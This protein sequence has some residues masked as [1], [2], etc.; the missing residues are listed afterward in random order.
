MSWNA[1]AKHNCRMLAALNLDG[2]TAKRAMM[3]PSSQALCVQE[4]IKSGLFGQQTE[5]ICVEKYHTKHIQQQVVLKNSIGNYKFVNA[6]FDKYSI[7]ATEDKSIDYAF[8]D[9]CGL[10]TKQRQKRIRQMWIDTEATICFTLNIHNRFLNILSSYP[11][12]D[13]DDNVWDNIK[14]E[15][16]LGGFDDEP[17]LASVYQICMAVNLF[18]EWDNVKIDSAIE[19]RNKGMK[20]PMLFL[21]LK[22]S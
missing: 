2:K 6:N 16:W 14:N 12:A 5:I 19:Y 7:L 9:F 10:L 15:K 21:K 17:M 13:I 20:H 18:N 1:T 4:S 3:F 8:F 11:K 22:L